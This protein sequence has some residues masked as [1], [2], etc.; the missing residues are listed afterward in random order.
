[1]KIKLGTKL[2]SSFLIIGILPLLLIGGMAWYQ[3]TNG[4]NRLATD[5]ESALQSVAYDK[6]KAMRDIKVT[7]IE[8]FFSK[9]QSDI[10]VLTQTVKVLREQAINQLTSIRENKAQMLNLLFKQ[11][12]SDIKAQQTQAACTQGIAVFRQYITDQQASN[13]YQQFSNSI[14]DYIKITDYHDY[15]IIDMQGTVL[16]SHQKSAIDQTNLLTGTYSKTHLANAFRK[17]VK[18]KIV[19]EDFALYQPANQEPVAFL[20]SPI[21]DNQKQT[22]VVILQV[23][24]QAIQAI[25]TPRQGLGETG[26]AYLVGS[27]RLMR[28]DSF[29]DTKLHS[30]KASL[31][32]PET[33]KVKTDAV[34]Q[35]LAGNTGENVIL[36][37][38]NDHVVSAWRPIKFGDNTW[39]LLIEADVAE[40]FC[41]V[42]ENKI[43]YY[44]K[45]IDQYGY[46]DL[47]LFTPDGY[48]FYTATQKANSQTNLLTGQFKDSGLGQAI[49]K[50]LTSKQFAFADYS[51][52]APSN[53]APASFMVQPIMHEGKVELLLG[54]Q[55]SDKAINQMMASGTNKENSLDA[56]L[57]GSD[58]RMRS[59]SVLNPGNYSIAASFAQNN[60][61]S[62]EASESAL[63]G[64][65]D[66]QFIKD[67]LGNPVLSAWAPLNIFGNQWAV[68]CEIDQ[69]SVMAASTKIEK[70][71]AEITSSLVTSITGT[72]V[73]VGIIVGIAGF[74][75]ARSITNPLR[76]IMT[77]LTHGSRQ[78]S[79]ASEQISSTS[80]SLAEGSCQQAA[81]L[82]ETSAS[83]EQM[84]AAVGQNSEHAMQAN[85]QAA[86]TLEIAQQGNQAMTQLSLTI[87]K[88]K[89]SS[90][91]TASILKTIDEIAFQTNLLALNAAVEAARAGDA[92]KG[93][94]VVAEEVRAL[95]QRSA[96][97]SKSTALLIQSSGE[98]ADQGVLAASE[99]ETKLA[100]INKETTE[101]VEL[102]THVANASREQALA[103]AQVSKAVTQI[104]QVTQSNAANA[105]ESSAS[106]EELFAQAASL[107]Q[108]IGQ[109]GCLVEGK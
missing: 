64:K 23:G 104:D 32:N 42:D 69:A 50:A 46:C 31:T 88:I 80:Q 89:S 59:D 81:S 16:Y 47:F 87:K 52:Y 61:I 76:K 67:Y 56:Y 25:M 15:M 99:T 40:V 66:E 8:Q 85:K 86:N 109:L 82:E 36:D 28:S 30:L 102:I 62:T 43:S 68:I 105:E 91:Q 83:L 48:C 107:D 49:Q 94:A 1:M 45:Y 41:P 26:E 7:K 73:I 78:V 5:A 44:Q 38:N 53:D 79:N 34:D 95:A 71:S 84:T 14:S 29:H 96:E 54:L 33:G 97:A 2:I 12:E 103:I 72:L 98:F 3:A 13:Q 74:L 93:F 27:D 21:I 11:Y 20:A 55:L 4:L 101:V 6:L 9:S 100:H 108:L 35:A 57:V 90:D 39:A 18:G 106:S 51:P 63:S 58:K 60:L 65:T 70:E 22:G 24:P 92:G 77:N 75:I 37:Y 10:N 19:F 17:A